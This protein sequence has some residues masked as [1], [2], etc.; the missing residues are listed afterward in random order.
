MN[1]PRFKIFRWRAVGIILL[2]LLLLVLCWALFGDRFVRAQMEDNLSLTL[3]TQ[4][5]IGS[6]RIR[7]GDVAV[8]V[9]EL[10]IADPRNP[11]R[12]L[13]EAGTIT[14]DLDPV[15]LAE[16]KL[17]IDQVRLS[18]LRFL[19]K[20]S[21]PARPADPN[22]PA[23]RLLAETEAWAREKFSFPSLALGRVDT[24]KS[25]VLNPEELGTVKAARAFVSQVDSTTAAFEQSLAGLQVK[26]VVDSAAALAGRLAQADPRQLGVAGVRDL[27]QQAQRSLDGVKQTRQRLQ[28]LEQSARGSLARLNRG[29]AAV[30]AAR[31]QDYSFARGLLNLPSFDGP[32]IGQS[33]FG[34]QSIDYF[35]RALYYAQLLQQYVPP[36]LQPWNRPGPKRT[37]MDGTDV[38]FPKEK[39]YPT[40]LLRQGSI[41]LAAGAAEQH[42]FAA[43]FGGLTS[44][45]A[46]YGRPAT[47]TARGT[48]GG[49]HPMGVDL[50]LLSRHFG[51]APRDSLAAR[52]TGVPLPP[53]PLPALP[54]VVNPG[55]STVGFRFSLA[56]DELRG[57]WEIASDQASWRA[58]TAQLRAAGLVENTVWRV[59]S[60]LTQLRVRAELRGTIGSPS[61]TVTSNLDDAI[62]ARL[63]GLVTEELQ[64]AEARARAAVD[65]IVEQQVA[66]LEAKVGEFSSQALA[67]LPVEKSQLDGVQDQL[68]RQIKRLAGSA[69]G[70]LRLPKL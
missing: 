34:R 28:A 47:L 50:S 58:D 14:L 45:P 23:G 65:R 44:Q 26:P 1:A 21:T 36:G 13:L 42:Q 56:G 8:D 27:V 57:S 24:V 9:G 51:A 16:K 61:L 19:T 64:R 33:L 17:V 66:G 3:G 12:N 10:T 25:L 49:A 37:R 70:G 18:G 22:S 20:R 5:D 35:G 48:I 59:V 68:D 60:G 29:L 15:P 55:P 7:E 38:E 46:L 53:I 4:V 6:L 69:A 2:A 40:F 67:R 31:Q 52:V 30:D 54:F 62:A 41:D 39:A 63:Q 32:N 43:T 11:H